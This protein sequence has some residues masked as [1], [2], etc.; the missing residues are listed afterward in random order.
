MSHAIDDS[1]GPTHQSVSLSSREE[2]SPSWAEAFFNSFFQEKNIKWMLV[3]GAAIVFGS[4]L[5]LVTKA[6]PEWSIALKYLT[7]VGYTSVIFCAAEISRRRLNLPATYHVLQALTLLLLP[8]C[9]LSLTWLSAGSGVQG[10]MHWLK[11]IGLLIP[12]IALLWIAASTILDHWLHGRQTTFLTSFS[13]LC[14]AGAIPTISSQIIAF[15]FMTLCWLAF[16]AGVV[17][18]NRHTFWLA[19]QHQLPRIFG[20]LPITLLGLQFVTL[21]AVKSAA[22]LPAQWIGFAVVMV[23]ATILMTTRTVADVF[24]QRTGDLV[25]P[26]PWTIVIPLFVGLVSSVAGLCLSLVGFSYVGPT[27][28]AV[29]P[30]SIVVAFVTWMIARDTKHPAFVWASLAVITLAYQCSPTLFAELVQSAKNATADAINQPRVPLSLYG[31]TYLPLLGALAVASRQMTNRGLTH[32]S[33]PIKQFV[34]AVSAALFFVAVADVVLL[35]FISPF[36]VSAANTIVFLAYAVLFRDRRFVIPSAASLVCACAT[37][38]PALSQMQYANLPLS[39]VPAILAGVAVLMTVTPWPDRLL[40]R[41]PVPTGDRLMATAQGRH[42][43]LIQL[44]GCV[45]A[46]GM[47]VHWVASTAIAFTTALTI[48][49]LLQFGLLML[50]LVRYTISN[51]H[52]VPAASVWVFAGYASLRW[53]AGLGFSANE[54]VSLSTYVLIGLSLSSLIILR[55]L[56]RHFGMESIASMRQA[57]GFDTSTASPTTVAITPDGTLCRVATFALPLF[58][59][60]LIVLCTLIASVFIPAVIIQHAVLFGLQTPGILGFGWSTTA[61]L[62]WLFILAAASGNRTFGLVAALL[63]PLVVSSTLITGGLL[64]GVVNLLMVWGVVQCGLTLASHQ[65][66]ARHKTAAGIHTIMQIGRAWSCSLLA[67]SC[68]SFALPMRFVAIV[69]AFSLAVSFVGRWDQW[70]QTNL[71]ILVNVNL[72]L[73][74]AAI[75]GCR[76]WLLPGLEGT[77][78]MAAVPYVFLTGCVSALLFE[79]P[80]RYLQEVLANQW[81]I[82][83]RIGL[84]PLAMGSLFAERFD[85][86]CLAAM[87]SGFITL[88]LAELVQAIKTRS[89]LRVWAACLIGGLLSLF[90]YQQN[91][92]SFGIGISQMVLLTLSIVGLSIAHFSASDVQLSAFRRPMCVIGL[93]L[94]AIVACLAIIREFAGIYTSLTALNALS[95]MIAAGIYFHQ[96][97]LQG[98]RFLVLPAIAI[99]N[100]GVFLLWKSLSWS[101]PELYLVPIG[102]SILGLSEMMKQELPAA[103]RS[104]LHYIGLL[105]V[106]CSPLPE[107]IGGSWIHIFAL[108]ALSVGVILASIGL[109]MRSLMYAGTAF[110]LTDLVAMVIR[111]TVNNAN[112]LWICGVVLGIGVITLAAFC[113]NHREK[114]LA[115]IRFLSA[116]L[117]TWN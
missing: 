10:N 6:W 110:L 96:A 24:R 27:T 8:V 37:V 88:I 116:E 74:A 47:G 81:A 63:L 31:L 72:L 23:S 67:I 54:L 17:K 79:R 66:L 85:P 112:L 91:F 41:I 46:I 39:W 109:R 90:L 3:V 75:G 42:R 111:S 107:V 71:A 94:P 68:L 14:V 4:S 30:T 5:M 99:A 22:V 44:T 25:R 38:V 11:N 18:V 34:T 59:L 69:T 83:L 113:E 56:R 9:F 48:A 98:R 103:A 102:I 108:M 58:D 106:L 7:I 29:I 16:T 28:Y 49:S 97:T 51:A 93:S 57:M 78:D 65:I 36:L 80:N 12:A 32:F 105:T 92:I 115:R 101:A 15:G 45:L 104:P 53:G 33:V 21:V 62:V 95:L 50:A 82:V 114:L 20:F 35:K 60:S 73:A 86:A 70:K 19:E 61:I 89:E 55:R 52:Y 43:N 64:S 77:I 2:T 40:Q 100:A 1:P 117:A 84:L 76:G 13:V 26:L 87:I